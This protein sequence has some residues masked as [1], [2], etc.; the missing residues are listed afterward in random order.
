MSGLDRN[1]WKVCYAIAIMWAIF[2]TVFFNS[3]RQTRDI[4]ALITGIIDCLVSVM[5]FMISQEKRS[6]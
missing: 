6:K 2:A 5:W 1:E 4:F 3:F